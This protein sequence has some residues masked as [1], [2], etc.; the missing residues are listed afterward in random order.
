MSASLGRSLST[1]DSDMTCDSSGWRRN[2][3]TASGSRPSSRTTVGQLNIW[4]L[5][6][7][8]APGDDVYVSGLCGE[9]LRT[10]RPLQGKVE[11]RAELVDR[12]GSGHFG[13]L[14][15]LH[16]PFARETP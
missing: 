1:T 5:E 2:N 16:P 15:L 13:Q 6:A 11:S 10:Y 8:D 3:R 4:D 9:M 12:F 14:K 7:P